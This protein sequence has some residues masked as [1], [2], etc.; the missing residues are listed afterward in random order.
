MI[1]ISTPTIELTDLAIGYGAEP[2]FADVSGRFAAGSLTAIIGPNGGGKSTLA[3]AIVGVLTPLAGTVRFIGAN[4]EQSATGGRPAVGYLAQQAE[5]DQDF[6]ISVFDTVSLGL[7]GEVGFYGGLNGTHRARIEAAL[8]QV[9]LAD[10]AGHDLGTLSGGQFRRVLFARLIAQDAPVLL[11]D[12]PFSAIDRQTTSELIGLMAQWHSE[13]RTVIVVLHNVAMVEA[14]FP[15]TLIMRGRLVDW[16]PSERVLAG[17]DHASVEH[18]VD[19]ELVRKFAAT[20]SKNATV[21]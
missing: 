11:L 10:I 13:G 14:F 7:L 2:V 20:M 18:G 3:K 21:R 16:G 12:E 5:L 6:P 8:D 17:Q 19:A 9:G 15:E 1:T 4:G